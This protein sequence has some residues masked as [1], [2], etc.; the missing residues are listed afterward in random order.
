[1]KTEKYNGAGLGYRIRSEC[2]HGKGCYHPSQN[3]VLPFCD[4]AF[5]W[6][7]QAPGKSLKGGGRTWART[8]VPLIKRSAGPSVRCLGSQSQKLPVRS[9][10]TKPA[11][12]PPKNHPSKPQSAASTASAIWVVV[13]VPPRSGLRAPPSSAFATAASMRSASA[14]MFSE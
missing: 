3:A 13:I 8:E 4:L 9:R 6:C 10:P 14:G 1:V 12:P 2:L 5:G 7:C 11:F